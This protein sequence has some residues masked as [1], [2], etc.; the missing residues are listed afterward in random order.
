MNAGIR[1]LL[2]ASLLVTAVVSGA[3][4]E[5]PTGITVSGVA[6]VSGKPDIA[7]LTVGVSTED[8]E[9]AKAAST[10]AATTSAVIDAIVRS[11]VAKNDIETA[12]YTVSPVMDYRSQRPVTTGYQVSNI[13]RVTVRDLAKVGAVIDAAMAS[14]A[15]NVQSVRFEVKDNTKLRQR[16]LVEAIANARADAELIASTMKVRLGK[17]VSVTESGPTIPRPLEFSAMKTAA[18]TPILPGDVDVTASVTVVYSIQ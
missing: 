1:L 8:K 14:G 13:V 5:S 4:G 9:A 17:V 16:A 3:Y 11:G 7:Y 18:E 15:N 6:I 12:Q 10:N 2:I